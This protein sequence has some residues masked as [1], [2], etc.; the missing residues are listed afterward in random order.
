MAAA[1]KSA[2]EQ[3]VTLECGDHAGEHGKSVLVDVG[4]VERLTH[5]QR[6]EQEQSKRDEPEQ[7]HQARPQPRTGGKSD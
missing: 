2:V 3:A 4:L 5:V 6:S 7:R 1:M